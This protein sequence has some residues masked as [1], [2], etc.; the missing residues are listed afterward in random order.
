MPR[1]IGT[2]TETVA[3]AAVVVT[4]EE[5][6]RH[7]SLALDD[8]SNEAELEGY[9]AAATRYGQRMEGQQYIE[10]TFTYDLDYF[11]AGIITLPRPPLSSITSIQYVDTNGDT[12]TL[13]TDV[14]ETD[15][16]SRPAR[17]AE[18]T[19][20]VWPATESGLNKVTIT[21]V[22]GYGTARTDVPATTRH[23]VKMLAAHLW[24]HREPMLEGS[25][26]EVPVGLKALF[27]IEKHGHIF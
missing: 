17:I 4:T 3:P 27:R 15:A 16:K 26:I 1:Q 11:P 23:A 10:A 22:A 25:L 21:Y 2:V 13:S 19:G 9:V 7:L 14:Y 12:Q 6:R 8:M 24:T 5:L 20:Q 18:K